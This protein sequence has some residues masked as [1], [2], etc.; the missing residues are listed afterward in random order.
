MK[1]LTLLPKLIDASGAMNQEKKDYLLKML[2]TYDEVKK[3]ELF[4]IL[5]NEQDKKHD[6]NE[7]RLAEKKEYESKKG[8][9]LRAFTERKSTEADEIELQHLEQ[10][11]QAA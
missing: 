5:K 2:S 1:D 6:L 11:L 9:I 8:G 4:D 10:E 7:R 3:G